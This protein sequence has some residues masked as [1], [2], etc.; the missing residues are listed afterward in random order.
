MDSIASIR[1]GSVRPGDAGIDPYD[2]L[3]FAPS[4]SRRMAT[5]LTVIAVRYRRAF[6]SDLLV[7]ATGS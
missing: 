4:P 1:M 3:K 5:M 7:T 2:H 6:T